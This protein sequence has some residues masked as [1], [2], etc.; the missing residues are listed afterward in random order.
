MKLRAALGPALALAAAGALAAAP[1]VP[2]ALRFTVEP[3]V[4]M[5]GQEVVVMIS[6]FGS[7]RMLCSAM[8]VGADV[9]SDEQPC[10]TQRAVLRMTPTVLSAGKVTVGVSACTGTL[11]VADPANECW[12]YEQNVDS[13]LRHTGGSAA[14]AAA[15]TA[16]PPAAAPGGL[17]DETAPPLLRGGAAATA[18]PGAQTGH[19]WSAEPKPEP[20]A[21]PSGRQF[22]GH[23]GRVYTRQDE[24]AGSLADKDE[25]YRKAL[26]GDPAVREAFEGWRDL[27]DAGRRDAL[28]RMSDIQAAAYGVEPSQVALHH[29]G[30]PGEI[31]HYSPDDRKMTINTASPYYNS[32][33]MQVNAISHEARHRWQ[34]S[35]VERLPALRGDDRALAEAFKVSFDNY[36]SVGG[37]RSCDYATYRHQL[38]ELDAFDQ[39]EAAALYLRQQRP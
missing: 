10:G 39:G 35:M 17:S 21:K 6:A 3:S 31:A 22:R 4:I 5:G 32:P 12:S 29:G 34:H 24:T 13:G 8:I 33:S 18:A 23:D 38:V 16:P 25:K 2:P 37:V 19:R 36:C 7:K 14:P 20:D 11:R 9:E 1:D 27:D 26:A 28:Q 15:K 30:G